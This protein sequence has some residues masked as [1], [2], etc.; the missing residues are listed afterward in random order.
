MRVL[1]KLGPIVVGIAS[2]AIMLGAVTNR[3]DDRA[4][5]VIPEPAVDVPLAAHAGEEHAV[6]SGGCFWGVQLVF[7]HVRGVTHVESGYAGGQASTAH[8]E[9]VG[10]GTTGHAESVQI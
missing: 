9:E 4:R 2:T 8:Y 7:Q 5:S 3:P 6:L 10:S 1:G